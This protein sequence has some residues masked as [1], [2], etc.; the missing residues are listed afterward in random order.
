MTNEEILNLV[1]AMKKYKKSKKYIFVCNPLESITKSDMPSNV[2]LARHSDVEVG[3]VYLMEDSQY[4]EFCRGGRMSVSKWGYHP[5][6][7]DGEYC[8]GDCD[9]CDKS[10]GEEVDILDEKTKEQ[11]ENINERLERLAEYVGKAIGEIAEEIVRLE[12]GIEK[13]L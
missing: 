6:R 13:N 11:L 4:N 10:E 1:K 7:C 2:I 5:D 3:N 8:P 9:I 12:N